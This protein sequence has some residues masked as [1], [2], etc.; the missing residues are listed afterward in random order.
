MSEFFKSKN[1]AVVKQDIDNHL[2]V[3]P[4]TFDQIE[5]MLF[6][7]ALKPG[8]VGFFDLLDAEFI[9]TKENKAFECQFWKHDKTKTFVF[10]HIKDNRTLKILPSKSFRSNI[11]SE[12]DDCQG[13]F[14][15]D[16]H[17]IDW[18]KFD[19]V[20]SLCMSIPYSIVLKHPKVLWCYYISEPIHKGFNYFR[21]GYDCYFNQ[22]CNG[23]V[24]QSI[25][26]IDIPFTFVGP[27]TLYSIL[28]THL[29]RDPMFKGIYA[30]INSVYRRPV[31]H[32]PQLE[33]LRDLQ[34]IIVHEP[35]IRDNLT[36]LYD[37]KYFVKLGGRSIR[38]NSVLEAISSH[39]L[40]LMD[41]DDLFS[42]K[43]LIPK[44]TQI[45][46][47]DDIRQKILFY[48]AYPEAYDAA[49]RQQQACLKKYALD[50][51]LKSIENAYRY[52]MERVSKDSP[53]F[54]FVKVSWMRFK[55]VLFLCCHFLLLIRK[56]LIHFFDLNKMYKKRKK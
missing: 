49:L 56:D 2:F 9:I 29:N 32:V 17:S 21:F 35:K 1:I 19:I 31:R 33:P 47:I 11:F 53:K 43:K 14:S 45:K 5:K 54:I 46:T 13:D 51:P 23:V 55:L 24:A 6:S 48:D 50:A 27:D 25:G 22:E 16:V 20:I 26:N 18:S 7:A 34:P 28:K 36:A 42:H 37:A 4:G 39:T 3:Y 8:P 38:G 10:S 15:V 52:K 40:V 30:E 41:P 44:E 12:S